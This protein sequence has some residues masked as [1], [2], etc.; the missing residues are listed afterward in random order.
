MAGRAGSPPEWVL[1]MGPALLLR[2]KEAAGPAAESRSQPEHEVKET[3]PSEGLA[4][5]Q[6]AVGNLA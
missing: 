3:V 4:A 1:L 6:S 5:Y 2:G